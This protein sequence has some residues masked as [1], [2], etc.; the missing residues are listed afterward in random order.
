MKT[1]VIQVYLFVSVNLSYDDNFFVFK[2]VWAPLE[3]LPHH[4]KNLKRC[5]EGY[6]VISVRA[7]WNAKKND[8]ELA[9][10]LFAAK[11]RQLEIVLRSLGNILLVWTRITGIEVKSFKANKNVDKKTRPEMKMA[12]RELKITRTIQ[13]KT[14]S[15]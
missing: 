12:R 14:N 7:L 3:F 8:E 2:E 6:S 4:S 11:R 15:A 9:K 1:N 13:M 5:P 10:C